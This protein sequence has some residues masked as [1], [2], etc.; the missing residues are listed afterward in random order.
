MP[1]ERPPARCPK[2]GNEY[3]FLYSEP[4]YITGF[5]KH[6]RVEWLD[7]ECKCG[8]TVMTP[9]V[10]ANEAERVIKKGAP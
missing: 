10:D 5:V 3:G 7:W 6:A 2:C 4:R 1:N 9:T 8:Y